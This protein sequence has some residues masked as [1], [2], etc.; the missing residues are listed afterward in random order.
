MFDMIVLLIAIIS[1]ALQV[2]PVSHCL[3][4]L[5]LSGFPGFF[6]RYLQVLPHTVSA[7]LLDLYRAI[8]WKVRSDSMW[9]SLLWNRFF[10]RRAVPWPCVLFASWR[11]RPAFHASP[12]WFPYDPWI[13][14]RGWS[15]SVPWASRHRWWVSC[16]ILP[17]SQTC[18]RASWNVFWD[19]IWKV[20]ICR[21]SDN[22]MFVCLFPQGPLFP[23]CGSCRDIFS[24]A[25]CRAHLP[26]TFPYDSPFV[27]RFLASSFPYS[28]LSGADR[29]VLWN[30][31][32]PSV[33]MN[34]RN[35]LCGDKG[36]YIT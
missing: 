20:R 31:P 6:R 12:S 13:C 36:I 16:Q 35:L 9:M 11:C 1:F 23:I 5:R 7:D 2:I 22:R 25:A 4:P 28:M 3:S 8:P 19:I 15:L 33:S 18:W 14:T 32:S 27:R 21:R 30:R 10:P 29:A 24:Q 34:I 26:M 17:P